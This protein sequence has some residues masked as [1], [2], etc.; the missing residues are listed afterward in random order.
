MKATISAIIPV[1]N[2]ASRLRAALDSVRAQT[3]LPIELLVIDDG[4]TDDWRRALDSF[5]APFPVRVVEQPNQGQ[6]AARNHGARLATGD[7][8]AFLDQDDEWLPRHLEVLSTPFARHPEVGWVYNDFDE[9]DGSGYV[10]TRAFLREFRVRNP[11]SSIL[12]CVSQDLMVLP[13]ASVLRRSMF[14]QAEG[15][16][17][18]LCG[19]EDDDLF[20]RCFRAGWGHRFMA[21]PLTRFRIHSS[22]SSSTPRFIASRLRYAHKLDAM[23][24]HADRLNRDYMRDAVAPRF[25]NTTLDDYVRAC[26]ARDWTQAR[27]AFAALEHFAK[28][29][30]GRLGTR[31]KLTLIRNPRVFRALMATNDRVPL[32]IR[33]RAHPLVRLRHMPARRLVRSPDVAVTPAVCVQLRSR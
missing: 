18:Q 28:L 3:L 30:G 23:L 1:F 21:Q 14:E 16:D 27:E 15:F 2:G 29:R 6:S 20:V 5:D 32:S 26:S 12:A 10:V 33:W 11:K 24:T 22:S 13:S 25:F 7:L 4:S 8:L 19:Y 31:W 9:I 17:E